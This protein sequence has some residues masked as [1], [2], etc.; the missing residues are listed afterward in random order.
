MRIW[1]A[2]L[3]EG[4]SSSFLDLGSCTNGTQIVPMHMGTMASVLSCL[5]LQQVPVILF[6]GCIMLS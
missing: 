2:V 1:R 5:M 6:S 3:R 4:K